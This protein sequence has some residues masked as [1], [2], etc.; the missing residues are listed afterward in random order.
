VEKTKLKDF[1]KNILSIKSLLSLIFAFILI[2]YLLKKIDIPT[3]VQIMKTVQWQYYLLA[4]ALFYLSILI[5]GIRWKILLNS[6]GLTM[7][8][9]DSTE[10]LF[11]SWFVNVLVPAKLGDFYRSH[12]IN[13]NYDFS[14]MKSFGTIFAERSIDFILLVILF[15]SS[16]AIVFR[17]KV[18]DVFINL[19]VFGIFL[20]VA[21][22]IIFMIINKYS[23][24]IVKILPNMLKGFYDRFII[25]MKGSFQR[26]PLLI[27]MTSM[28][29][30]LEI[31]R[32][33]FVVVSVNIELSFLLAVFIALASSLLTT[34]P[35]TPAGLGAVEL[36]VVGIL[37][38][39]NM[40]TNTAASVAILDRI[41]SFWS[42]I[43]LGFLV[44]VVSAKC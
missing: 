35:I 6:V 16:G 42:I 2:F 4:F 20:L 27:S 12:L 37:V 23:N 41:I 29:W 28:I 36:A 21:L 5:R 25:G 18:P 33:Y 38:I 22:V 30:L 31:L 15:F 3:T 9:K 24:F 43:P 8:I 40:D 44:F 13:R 7:K 17:D 19:I 11:L 26:M 14:T 34:L 1:K 32:F 10:I 39:F